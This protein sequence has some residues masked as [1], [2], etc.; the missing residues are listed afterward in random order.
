MLTPVQCSTL[1]TLRT[2]DGRTEMPMSSLSVSM[3]AQIQELHTDGFLVAMAKQ[4]KLMLGLT[5]KGAYLA[6][7]LNNFKT[8]KVRS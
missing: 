8:P 7:I 2:K 5:P 6:L 3:K 1:N 4:G